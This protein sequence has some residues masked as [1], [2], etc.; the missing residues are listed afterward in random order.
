MR[1]AE[2]NESHNAAPALGLPV[3]CHDLHTTLWPRKLRTK[4]QSLQL[5]PNVPPFDAYEARKCC[6]GPLEGLE[7]LLKQQSAP[8]ETAAVIIEPIMGEGGF[9]TPPPGF[10]AGLRRICDQNNMLLIIDE[11]CTCALAW[12][13]IAELLRTGSSRR[14]ASGGGMRERAARCNLHAGV[15]AAGQCIP[16]SFPGR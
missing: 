8:S 15:H 16:M 13:C 9:L 3:C 10:L 11:V 2:S 12:L 5:A 7:W 4:I 1:S 6:G 14:P